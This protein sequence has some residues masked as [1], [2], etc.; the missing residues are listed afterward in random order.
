MVYTPFVWL[1]LVAAVLIAG[2]A[3]YARRFRG[4]PAAKPFAVM[5]WLTAL[6][7]LE[8][9]LYISTTSL[10]LKVFLMNLRMTFGTF[11]PLVIL[12]LVLEYSGQGAWLTRR[13]L[14][15][16]LVMPVLTVL[17]AWS[18]GYH[19]LYRYNP[20]LNLDA[21][22]PL[23]IW[24]RGPL[25][26]VTQS[27]S[28]IIAL[29]AAWILIR[30]LR[31]RT[32]RFRNTLILILGILIPVSADAL[33][34]IEITPWRGY[35]PAST[36]CV[37]TGA[38][39]AWAL[40]RFRLLGI[41]PVA[42]SAAMDAIDD[43]VVVL[44]TDDHLVDFN[45]AA[46]VAFGLAARSNGAALDALPPAWAGLLQRY[47]GLSTGKEQVTLDWG[48]GPHVYEL[49]VSIIHDARRQALG[50]L[51][52]LHDITARKQVDEIIRLRLRLLEFAADHSVLEVMQQALDEIGQLTHSPIGFYHFVEVDQKTLSL[53][54][55]STR[56][57][58]EFCTAESKGLHYGLDEAGVWVDC[59]R[60]REPVIHNDYASLPHR[61]GM[62]P[63]HAEVRR[64]LVVP[65]MRAGRIVSVLGVGNKPTDY[66]ENDVDLV[67][68][69]ADIV[70]TI[71]ERKQAEATLRE[72][73]ERHRTLFETIVQ[74]I[75]YQ[76]AESR[77]I[78]AN[79]AAQEIL[80]LTL[81]QMQGRTSF[82][83]RWKAI[84]EDGSDFPGDA[85]PA[86]VA[87]RTGQEVRDVVM[88][89]FNP[90]HNAYTWIN[91]D[92]VPQFKAGE[93]SPWQV[94]TTFEDITARRQAQEA[95]RH[96]AGELA[97][98]N[99]ELDAFAHTVAHDLKNPLATVIGFAEVLVSDLDTMSPKDVS[100]AVR[101]ISRIGQRLD[102]IIDE[103]MLLA[104]IRKQEVVPEP[105]DMGTVVHAALEG[106]QLLIQERHAQVTVLDGATW[107]V[108][109]GYAPWIA[110]V[111]DN[112][113]SNAI[114]YGGRPP[115]IQ[116]G[117]DRAGPAGPSGRLMARF[118][119]QDNGPGL[120][121][122]AQA[123]LFTPF[124]RLDQVHVQGHG[125]GL[126]IVRRIVEK[127]GGQV[128]VESR[129]GQGSRFYFTLPL[130]EEGTRPAE[131]REV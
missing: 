129:P 90:R 22:F 71:V 122:E 10:P 58:R 47:P 74:G 91:V 124:T 64:E 72:S 85:H 83:P 29:G 43:L 32:L 109:L 104:G 19:S 66:D 75:V 8:Y 102:R 108:T 73:E 53:Q 110:Q 33:Y 39:L 25:Y 50:R 126:S 51:L 127:L 55:W 31:A 70:W 120:S 118:W 36:T 115:Q 111:W 15:A 106:L 114:K 112:Y 96:Y 69:V 46:Q 41:A 95:L 12:W 100:G 89:V 92:A 59:I 11:L 54:A 57:L 2:Q 113:I 40:L 97:A 16:L 84:R 93:H 68:Y 1:Q 60:Q 49:T 131:R 35:N 88:G 98:Q 119:V 101:H 121:T 130:G 65:T 80:G 105:L 5:M 123:R 82:D 86:M 13:R 30:S 3:L 107:P 37:I 38:L 117:A 14:A 87:L 67:A 125:L 45:R 81:D 4:V 128:G 77:I 62:P 17:L 24:S 20:R 52:V 26:W 23:L 99:A 9:A 34:N 21:P 27:Y 103:L 7:A 18:S 79:P 76:D 63:G 61:K 42:R 44:D 48:G 56:T 28:I 116:M 94:Y 6:W 78:S